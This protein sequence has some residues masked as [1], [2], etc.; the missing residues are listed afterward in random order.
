[1]TTKE[2]IDTVNIETLELMQSI[3]DKRLTLLK[4]MKDVVTKKRVQ[5]FKTYDQ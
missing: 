3:I 5:G 1:M 2:F 4:T